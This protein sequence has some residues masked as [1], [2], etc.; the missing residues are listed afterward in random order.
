[1]I[2]ALVFVQ[3][4][5]GTSRIV[6][7]RAAPLHN[8]GARDDNQCPPRCEETATLRLRA[9][10][11]LALTGFIVAPGCTAGGFLGRSHCWECQREISW[12]EVFAHANGSRFV[13]QRFIEP[14]RRGVETKYVKSQAGASMQP[15]LILGQNHYLPSVPKSPEPLV[16]DHVPHPP[17]ALWCISLWTNPNGPDGCSHF[18]HGHSNHMT[19]LRPAVRKHVLERFF[20]C[21]SCEVGGLP[22]SDAITHVVLEAASKPRPNLLPGHFHKLEIH[23]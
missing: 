15:D 8:L 21:L 20:C 7:D 12:L 23:R 13:A 4:I 10:P 3:S 22:R 17:L 9:M 2:G 19:R 18:I 5:A 14:A 11:Q 1:M 6:L 16:D